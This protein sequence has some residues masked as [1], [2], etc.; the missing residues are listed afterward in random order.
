MYSADWKDVLIPLEGPLNPPPFSPAS[1]RTVWFWEL[2]KYVGMPIIT[3]QN[4]NKLVYDDYGNKNLYHCPAQKDEYVFNGYGVHYGMNIFVCSLIQG[5]GRA[6]I[7]IHKW[8]K[9]PRK[10]DLIYVCD[11]MDASGARNDPRLLYPPGYAQDMVPSYFVYSQ[12]WG[13]SFDIP[14]SD[15]HAGGSNILF[16][17]NSVRWMRMDDFTVYIGDPYLTGDN[18]K[19]RMWDYRL[20]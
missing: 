20:P 6:F 3:G 16:M 9:M 10:S 17:D 15:R 5:T 7:Y 4:V 12:G 19:A 11:T 8:S 18:H 13:Q 2:N 14:P 1:P